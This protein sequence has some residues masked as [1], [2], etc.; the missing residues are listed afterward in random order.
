MSRSKKNW[1]HLVDDFGNYLGED[2][3]NVGVEKIVQG[4]EI[5]INPP[6]GIG[7]V[8][9]SVDPN[10]PLIRDGDNISKLDNDAGYITGVDTLNDIGDV[11][12]PNPNPSQVLTWTGTE[13]AAK[14]PG[15]PDTFLYRGQLDVSVNHPEPDPQEGWTYIHNGADNAVPL[16]SWVGI[17]SELADENDLVVYSSTGWTLVKGVFDAAGFKDLKVVN[18]PTPQAG[19]PGGYL[20]YDESIAT[21]TYFPAELG[22]F[23]DAGDDT[24]QP[25]TLDD[26]YVNKVGDT[27]SGDLNM[28]ANN[29][30]NV[31]E[32]TVSANLTFTGE[33]TTLR[34]FNRHIV[35]RGGFLSFG[36]QDSAVEAPTVGIELKRETNALV[37]VGLSQDPYLPLHA[38]TKQYVDNEIDALDLEAEG[39][40]V[41]RAGDT[42]T[43][44]LSFSHSDPKLEF[45]SGE[46]SI[47]YDSRLELG[48]TTS[49][50]NIRLEPLETVF[51]GKPARFIAGDSR[52]IFSVSC[53]QVNLAASYAYYNGLITQPKHVTNKKYVDFN[54]D[55]IEL[56][57][58]DL[59]LKVDNLE[60]GILEIDADAK[61]LQDVQ[62]GTTTTTD[63]PN[64]ADVTVTNKNVLNFTIPRGEPGAQG[65]K[66]AFGS[67]GQPGYEGKKG[68]PGL[69]GQTGAG[70]KGQKGLSGSSGSKGQKGE[71]GAT[72][73]KGEVKG[74]FV[75]RGSSGSN[76]RIWYNNSKYY[77]SGTS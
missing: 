33:N 46:T 57:V 15:A 34:P 36:V 47:V 61:Y 53:D 10:A 59:E 28:D 23:P 77:I 74:S 31:E 25:G 42:M 13:W 69:K 16:A 43:G 7:T 54:D 39:K 18:S 68:E 3:S 60:L 32:L 8:T 1:D 5:T 50:P 75:F 52:D 2:F 65:I 14:T 37:Y 12:V 9:V 27:M 24:I 40:F 17:E 26:R 38:A 58:D 45:S 56:L 35:S 4:S 6:S 64:D 22:L 48:N 49:T 73:A 62:V 72:G 70:D 51:T 76:I 30:D 19:Q 44:D 67:K 29:I 41:F 71:T 20:Q 63:Y 11:N 55:R 21:F 66:G